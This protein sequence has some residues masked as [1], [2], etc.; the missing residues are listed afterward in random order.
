M[1]FNIDCGRH[2]HDK[3]RVASGH[4]T[5]NPFIAG[6]IMNIYRESP[7]PGIYTKLPF[8][9]EGKAA[10]V[11]CTADIGLIRFFRDCAEQKRCVSEL[12][13]KNLIVVKADIPSGVISSRKFSGEVIDWFLYFWKPGDK[14]HASEQSKHRPFEAVDLER[15]GIDTDYLFSIS[16]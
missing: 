5:S 4:T 7:L 14:H 2:Y 15:A 13:P 12:Y 16:E 8:I 10:F 11:N 9:R 3:Q 1:S 6:D